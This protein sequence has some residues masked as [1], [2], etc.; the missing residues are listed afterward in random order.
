MKG[1]GIA[2]QLYEAPT[3]GFESLETYFPGEDVMAIQ[4]TRREDE[5]QF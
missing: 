4:R 5:G 2:D 3:G 1:Q